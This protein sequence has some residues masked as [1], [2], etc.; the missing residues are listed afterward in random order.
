MIA[1]LKTIIEKRLEE[2]SSQ[3]SVNFSTLYDAGRYS[4]SSGG[5]RIRPLLT[6]AASAS[7]DDK[8]VLKAL[9]P[10][11]ALE[12]VHTYSLIHDDLPCMDNDD[13]RRG[14][15]TLHKVYNEGHAVLTG[16]FLLTYAFEVVANAPHLSSDQKI[17]LVNILAKSAGAEGMVGGQVMD[18]EKASDVDD[19]HARKT[20]ALFS[21]SMQ[22][23]SIV[24]NLDEKSSH[25][26]LNFG[27]LF[28]QL[29]QLVDD[30]MDND[31][32]LGEEAAKRS[33]QN[34]LQK[35]HETLEAF[36]GQGNYLKELVSLVVNQ[37]EYISPAC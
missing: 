9:D 13:F 35:V 34:V 30:L 10:A 26:L 1:Y 25:R 27:K 3:S 29:F 16:D 4:L 17:S 21:A 31:H 36:N 19:M 22:F 6:L 20:G 7:I 33:L 23:A 32:P 11:C 8:K 15:P 14:K 12:I 18:L 24:C 2:L 5:K 37:I 28:G